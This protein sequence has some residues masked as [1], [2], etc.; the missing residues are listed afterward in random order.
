MTHLLSVLALSE[1]PALTAGVAQAA[2]RDR[3]LD[4]NGVTD[5]LYDTDLNFTWPR[6]ADVNGIPPSCRG[7]AW[8]RCPRRGGA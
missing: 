3:D 8:R 1:T 7:R 6:I 5:T 4:G 2:L